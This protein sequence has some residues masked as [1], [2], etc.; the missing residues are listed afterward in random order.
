M[1]T[2]TNDLKIKKK[3]QILIFWHENCREFKNLEHPYLS[4][5]KFETINQILKNCHLDLLLRKKKSL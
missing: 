2:I 4:K 1:V 5:F 3:K